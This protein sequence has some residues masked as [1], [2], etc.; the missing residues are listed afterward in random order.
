MVSRILFVLILI[1]SISGCS[2]EEPTSVPPPLKNDLVDCGSFN[3]NPQQSLPYRLEKSQHWVVMGS[4]SAAGAGASHPSKN[5]VGLLR[6]ELAPQGVTIHNIAK[7]GHTTY[8]ALSK[9]C[10]VDGKR[11]QPDPQHNIDRAFNYKPDL[12]ILNYPGNDQAL[13]YAEQEPVVNLLRLRSELLESNIPVL[14]LSSQPRRQNLSLQK[15]LIR[16]NELIQPLSSPCFVETFSHL[17]N[18]HGFLKSDFDY[19]G[20]HLNDAGHEIVFKAI[21][22]TINTKQCI[23]LL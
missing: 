6:A 9:R 10:S 22:A 16:F 2:E 5:W 21:M 12:V 11:F 1:F 23:E 18:D 4:S 15:R 17:Q 13:N 14:I 20:V 19:D 3:L 8:H 7:G